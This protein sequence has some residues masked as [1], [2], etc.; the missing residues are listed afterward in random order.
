[1]IDIFGYIGTILILYSFTIEN[2]YKLRLINSIGSVFWIVYGIGIMAVPTIVVNSC[3]LCIHT[4][5]FIKQ[6]KKKSAN[7]TKST[8]AIRY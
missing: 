6:K 7:N 2:I 4:Y 8:K 3:V 5:W 1:M